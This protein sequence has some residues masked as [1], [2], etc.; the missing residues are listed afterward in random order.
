MSAFLP[1]VAT[2]ILL[3]RNGD[4]LVY[5]RDDKP[6]IPFPNHWDLFGGHVERGE[7]PEQALVREIQEELGIH[8]SDFHKFRTYECLEGDVRP[9]IK[10]VFWTQLDVLAEDLILYEGQRLVGIPL[11]DRANIHFANIL[12]R[13][14]DDFADWYIH[15]EKV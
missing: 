9:N 4:L 14:V 13:I 11:K 8:L 1:Q 15:R 6:T 3:D 10:H 12:S 7:S 5:L 2:A